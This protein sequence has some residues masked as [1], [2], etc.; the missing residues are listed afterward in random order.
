MNVFITIRTYGT[1]LH[2]DERG[3]VDRNHNQYGEPRLA[4]SPGLSRVMRKQMKDAP[5]VMNHFQR[6]FVSEAIEVVVSHRSWSLH[7]LN[8]RTNHVHIVVTA[9]DEI[10]PE[11]VMNTFKVWATRRLRKERSVSQDR[12]IWARHGSTLK[13]LRTQEFHNACHYVLNCQDFSG[14]SFE[15]VAELILSPEPLNKRTLSRPESGFPVEFQQ[16]VR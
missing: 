1:W 12:R 8:V 4:P 10:E 11:V 9:P 14:L 15:E 16:A 2:G 13:L 6:Q 7:A 5:F 3:S